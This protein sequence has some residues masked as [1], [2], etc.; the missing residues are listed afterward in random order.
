MSRKQKNTMDK[1]TFE[2]KVEWAFEFFGD[3]GFERGQ[4]NFA[5]SRLACCQSCG[6]AAIEAIEFDYGEDLDNVVFYHDQDAENLREDGWFYIA[7]S[8][9]GDKIKSFFENCWLNVEWNGDDTQRMKITNKI[10]Q[11]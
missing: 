8:G 4:N 11:S 7:W 9:D 1:M 6:W 5:G 3:D 10:A 2:Q